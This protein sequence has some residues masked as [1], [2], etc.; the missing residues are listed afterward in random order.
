MAKDG[1]SGKAQ[2]RRKYF[3]LNKECLVQCEK[4]VIPRDPGS[5]AAGKSL[6]LSSGG[7]LFESI[8]KFELGDMLRLEIKAD[9]WEKF[10]AEFYKDDRMSQS[11]PLFVLGTVVRSEVLSGGAYEIGVAFTGIDE[12][13]RW[14]LEKYLKA[15]GTKESAK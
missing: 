3:R 11:K 7:M 4:Y 13:H 6:N 15:H 10:S 14:A 8:T 12:G 9:G 5:A 1:V 2:E